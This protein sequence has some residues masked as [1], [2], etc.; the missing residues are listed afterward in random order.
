MNILNLIGLLLFIS[1]LIQLI[2]GLF[3]SFYFINYIIYCFK[4]IINIII[5]INY[6]YL[7]RLIHII[8]SSLFMLFLLFHFIRGI[9]YILLFIVCINSKNTWIIGLILLFI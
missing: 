1:F 2:S 3:N 7:I 5:N 8:G 9:Y 6:G 4:S